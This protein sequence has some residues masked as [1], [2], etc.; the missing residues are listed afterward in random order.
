MWF[1]VPFH[2]WI[3]LQSGYAVAGQL[4]SPVV[5]LASQWLLRELALRQ[6]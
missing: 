6:K 2:V 1:N 5:L 4:T 3:S